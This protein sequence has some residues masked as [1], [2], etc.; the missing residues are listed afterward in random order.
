MTAPPTVFIS[1]S[2]ADRVE[3]L[4]GTAPAHGARL[5]R[6]ADV[7][8]IRLS[9]ELK[10][11]LGGGIAGADV[12]WVLLSP[13]AVASASLSTDATDPLVSTWLWRTLVSEKSPSL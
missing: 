11:E 9:A 12:F 3:T 6:V 1:Y 4:G 5:H 10:H 8:D 2:S 7:F 13:T